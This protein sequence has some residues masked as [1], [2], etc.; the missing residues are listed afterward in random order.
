[1]GEVIAI[2]G[3]EEIESANSATCAD[4]HWSGAGLKQ[5]ACKSV[6]TNDEA[7]LHLA[8]K[9]KFLLALFPRVPEPDDCEGL[10]I[11]VNI[12]KKEKQIF[13]GPK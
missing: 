11:V 5:A 9:R 10:R 3:M 13:V 8:T 12:P 6:R 1:M 2:P 7:F 4:E